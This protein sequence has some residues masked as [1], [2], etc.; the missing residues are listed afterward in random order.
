MSNHPIL[1]LGSTGTTGRR[2]TE[3]L[4]TA[5]VSIRA[6]SRHGPV[7]FDWDDPATW[8][9]ALSGA[10]AV[11]L[12]LPHERPIEPGFVRAAAGAHL[13]LLSSRGIETMGDDRLL[14]AERAVRESGAAWTILRPDW[15]NQ[16]FDEGFFQPAV[17]AG[18][19]AMPVGDA[20]QVFVDADD[21]A[22]VAATVL[23]DPTGHAGH[24][25]DLT[26]PEALSFGEA[27]AVIAGAAGRPLRFAGDPE[28]YL[29][30]QTMIGLPEE[31]TRAEIEAFAALRDLGD[32]KP[33]DDVRRVTGHP[34]KGF[35]TYA[36]EA[37]ARGAWSG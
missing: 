24:T 26:G 8:P 36:E 4:R 18:Q 7:H 30:Q 14:A 1:V 33:T 29:A 35:A 15:F 22:A 23:A 9:P 37:A 17:V 28:T 10:T 20:R 34:P 31:Q 2:V 25:Y 5:G 13:V 3:R 6:A 11:Y 21:I 32:Q 27:A 19:L 12:M 16:N